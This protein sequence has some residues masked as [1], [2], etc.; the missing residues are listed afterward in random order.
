MSKIWDE[1]KHI[2]CGDFLQWWGNLDANKKLEWKKTKD[3]ID[4]EIEKDLWERE[5]RRKL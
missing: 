3:R 2:K 5:L 4:L 1:Y